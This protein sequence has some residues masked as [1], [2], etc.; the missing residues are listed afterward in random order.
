MPPMLIRIDR[1]PG[2]GTTEWA[3]VIDGALWLRGEPLT[4]TDRLEGLVILEA[5][6]GERRALRD[7]GFRLPLGCPRNVDAPR[8]SPG[9]LAER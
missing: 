5:L 2:A 1:G 6:L 3:R 7:L 9:R 4:P 8:P